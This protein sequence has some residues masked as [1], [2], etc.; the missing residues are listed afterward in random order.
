M[1]FNIFKMKTLKTQWGW[2][3][4]ARNGRIQ[5]DGGE[6]YFN[7]AD[8]YKSLRGLFGDNPKRGPEMEKEIARVKTEQALLKKAKKK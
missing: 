6:G 8:V 4:V 5:A 2:N 3:T 1:Q 7:L